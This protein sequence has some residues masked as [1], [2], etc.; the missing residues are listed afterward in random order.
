MAARATSADGGAAAAATVA[1]PTAQ[2]STQAC[3][4]RIAP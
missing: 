3:E 1:T 2:K 4:T